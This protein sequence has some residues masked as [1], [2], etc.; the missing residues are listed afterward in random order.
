MP[1]WRSA[2]ASAISSPSRSSPSR[3]AACSARRAR[4]ALLDEAVGAGRRPG[5]RPRS[6]RHRPR[7]RR[8]SR[9][10]F[11]IAEQARRRHRHPSARRRRRRHRPDAGD[12]RAHARAAASKGKVAISHA[13]ALGSVPTELAAR[14]A[15]TL[16]EA[17][18]AIMSHGP[19]AG[20]HAAAAAAARAWRRGVRRL[21]QHPRCLVAVRQRRHART[22]HAD[23]LSRQLPPRPR[24]QARLRDG[25]RG[26][27]PR[28]RHRPTT[29]SRSAARPTSSRSRRRRSPKPSLPARG[30]NG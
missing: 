2:S 19:G 24:A 13:F 21:R 15:D 6:G 1:C 5:G 4:P 28:A 30:A 27:G 18:I 8:P 29:A 20:D 12:R 25:D 23:R 22:R 11:A 26:R 3:K 16:A 10:I 9:P 14:T 17:G 7:P